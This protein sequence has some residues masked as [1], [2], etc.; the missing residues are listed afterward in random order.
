[1]RMD[2]GLGGVD[3]SAEGAGRHGVIQAGRRLSLAVRAFVGPILIDRGP[4]PS[5]SSR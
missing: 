4:A 5:R 1:M 3:R 2:G